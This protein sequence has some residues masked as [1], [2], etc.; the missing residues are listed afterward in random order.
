MLISQEDNEPE[1]G[2]SWKSRQRAGGCG[3]G[4]PPKQAGRA[5]GRAKV[6]RARESRGREGEKGRAGAGGD[7]HKIEQNEK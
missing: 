2:V 7:M 4:T 5:G 6:G 3:G 1:D